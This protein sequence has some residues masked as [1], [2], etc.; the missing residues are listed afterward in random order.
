MRD[1]ITGLKA[2]RS[3][4]RGYVDVY[5]GRHPLA[6]KNGCV[7]RHRL[8]LWQHLG[9]PATSECHFCG[10]ELPWTPQGD[11]RLVINVDHINS[12][13]GDDRLENLR[14]LC[15]WCNA[16]RPFIEKHHLSFEELID[17]WGDLPP[18]E[19]PNLTT[20]PRIEQYDHPEPW[21]EE[22]AA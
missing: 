1:P 12:T 8:I 9:E 21:P 2:W 22:N 6:R 15:F 3:D 7:K 20:Q 10:W 18:I 13:P 4:H 16:H 14:P 11:Y 19:R 5:T 17:R